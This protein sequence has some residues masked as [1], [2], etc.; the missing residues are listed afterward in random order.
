MWIN[1]ILL[2]NPSILES[3]I[4]L[5]YPIQTLKS[6]SVSLFAMKTFLLWVLLLYLFYPNIFLLKL[7]KFSNGLEFRLKL[8]RLLVCLFYTLLFLRQAL[9]W[10]FICL[11]LEV[12]S[13]VFDFFF[14]IV[15]LLL[16]LFVPGS[17]GDVQPVIYYSN[18]YWI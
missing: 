4:Q 16:L 11:C 15:A 8:V 10:D 5:L 6:F 17:I 18:I 9:I 2:K 14:S 13:F 7:A 1:L 3:L 12:F